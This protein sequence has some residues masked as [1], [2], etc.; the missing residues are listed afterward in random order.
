MN[1]IL[2]ILLTVFHPKMRKEEEKNND[3]NGSFQQNI[4]DIFIEP[5]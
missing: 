2:L 5:T 3:R 4:V 1:T